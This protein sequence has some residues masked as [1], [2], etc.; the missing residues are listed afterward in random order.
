MEEFIANAE[1]QV[2]ESKLKD[3]YVTDHTPKV[4]KYSTLNEEEDLEYYNYVR[5]VELYKEQAARGM[6]RRVSQF[7]SGRYE[8]GSFQQALFEPLASAKTL[9]NGTVFYELQEKEIAGKLNEELLRRQFEQQKDVNAI[10]AEDEN[11]TR[12]VLFDQMEEAGFSKEE[13][14]QILA[15][16]FNTFQEGEKYDYTIDLRRTFDEGLSTSS[17]DKIFA[18]LPDHVFWD[19]KKPQSPDEHFYMNKWNA[20]RQYPNKSFFD[21]RRHEDWIQSKEEKR[22][23]TDNISKYTRNF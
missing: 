7:R 2:L 3:V 8:L 13:W 10:E 15:R 20:A 1:K 4:T 18:K 16:E 11:E 5:S 6:E 12:M 23:L 21:M 17:F 9:E 19:I 14:D 22:N